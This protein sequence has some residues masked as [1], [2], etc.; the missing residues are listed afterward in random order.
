MRFWGPNIEISGEWIM[1]SPSRNDDNASKNSDASRFEEETQAILRKIS[2]NPVG[3]AVLDG[4][5][6]ASHAVTIRPLARGAIGKM[7]SGPTFPEKALQTDVGSPGAPGSGSKATIWF[8][9]GGVTVQGH[10]YRSDD[11]LLHES[12]HA[13]RQVLGLWRAT[14]LTGWDNREELYAT[15]V[16]NIY[17][18]KSGRRSDMRSS[19]SAAFVTMAQTGDQFSRQFRDEILDFRTF[20]FKTYEDISAVQAGWNPLHAFESRFWNR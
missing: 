2:T 9:A 1:N 7:R 14:P 10:L 3:K 19:H 5:T 8:N 13:L 12:F 20:M 17:A 6:K 18:S 15:M 4:F 11:S 16:T